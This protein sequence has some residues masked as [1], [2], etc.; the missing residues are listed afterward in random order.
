MSNIVTDLKGQS[1]GIAI[2]VLVIVIIV[3]GAVYYTQFREE[4]GMEV[5]NPNTLVD[6]TAGEPQTLDP[7]WA[8]DTASGEVIFNVYEPL[9]SFKGES[10]TEYEPRLAT[11]W[12]ISDDG[13]TYRFKI[14]D[15]ATFHNGNELTPSDVEYSIERAMVMDRDG[16]PS[17]MFL[18]PLLGVGSTR[19]GG[20]ISVDFADIDD[21]VEVDGDWVVFNLDSPYPPFMDILTQTWSSIIDQDW[22]ANQGAWPG[23]AD[24]WKDY[25]NPESP[26]LQEVMNGTGPFKFDRWNKG[27]EVVMKRNADYWRDSAEIETVRIKNVEEWSTRKSLFLNGDADF[28]YVPRSHSPEVEGVEGIDIYKGLANMQTNPAAFYQYQINENSDWIGSGELDGEGVP[29][30]F[31][32]DKHLRYAFSYAFDYETYIEDAFLGQGIK[33]PGPIPSAVRYFNSD[34]EMFSYNLEKAKEEF[35]KAFGGSVEDPGPV[36]EN[37]FTMTVLYNSGNTQRKLAA[38]IWESGIE[39]INDKFSIEIADRKWGTYLGEMV[40]GKLPIFIIGWIADYPDPHN[41]VYPFMHSNGTFS[42]W[43]GYSNSEVDDL[44]DQGISSTSE[45][46]REDVYYELQSIYHE[47]NPSVPLC[48]PSVRHYERSWVDGWFYNPIFPGDYFYTISKG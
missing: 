38:E 44:I 27:V 18:E 35:K 29:T 22:A 37:G 48:E 43:Q 7:A 19:S 40:S 31:F 8:Y 45:E 21:S 32:S 15:G 1:T 47:D 11:D 25:N 30:D 33:V 36:W 10:L 16:G 9:I 34:Q 20:E 41:F 6:A 24:T 23:T 42:R 5:Q 17:W 2:G 13:T 39:Q 28:C 4:G 46:T 12:E 26:P 3:G 14:R